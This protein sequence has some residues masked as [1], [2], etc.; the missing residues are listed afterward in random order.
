M[1][2]KSTDSAVRMR[3]LNSRKCKKEKKNKSCKT[4]YINQNDKSVESVNYYRLTLLRES[5]N[6]LD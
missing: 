2:S 5:L 4:E 6:A 3:S 1:S